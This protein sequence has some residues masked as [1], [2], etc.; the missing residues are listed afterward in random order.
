MSTEGKKKEDL[1]DEIGRKKDK[2]KSPRINSRGK[3][4]SSKY[5]LSKTFKSQCE[6]IT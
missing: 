3:V 5:Y 4:G 2:K 6:L 1:E